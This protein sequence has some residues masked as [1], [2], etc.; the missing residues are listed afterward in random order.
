M[1]VN[2]SKTAEQATEKSKE[3]DKK[4]TRQRRKSRDLGMYPLSSPS[5][6]P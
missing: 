6:L 5:L 4:V 2:A 3:L 1:S